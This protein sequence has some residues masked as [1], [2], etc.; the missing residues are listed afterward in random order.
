[1]K[2]VKRGGGNEIFIWFELGIFL[3]LC[4]LSSVDIHNA[5]QEATDFFSSCV[6]L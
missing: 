2:N 1:M 3:F 6:V 4:F 5:L